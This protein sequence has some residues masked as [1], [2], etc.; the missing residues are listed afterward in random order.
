MIKAVLFDIDGTLIDSNE[1]HAASFVEAFKFYGIEVPLDEMIRLIGMGA[2]KILEKYLDAKQIADFGEALTGRRKQIFLREHL[3]KLHTFPQLRELL[4]RLK[5]DGLRLALASSA[6][7]EE[8]AAYH[9]LLGIDD[10][11]DEETSSDDADESKPEPDIFL[12]ALES[13]EDVGAHEALVVGDTPYDAEAAR[14]ARMRIVGVETGGWPREELQAAGCAAVYADLA[15]L[16]RHYET[17]F[18][19]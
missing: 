17:V 4:A 8:L 2:D 14:R 12:A 13:L 18:A 5:A 15:G 6:S 3:P 11:L 9:E 16:L 1:A 19:R 7:K 10:L